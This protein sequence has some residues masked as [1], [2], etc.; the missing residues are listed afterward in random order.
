MV[1]FVTGQSSLFGILFKRLNALILTPQDAHQIPHMELFPYS[2][3]FVAKGLLAGAL[4]G[5]AG[6]VSKLAGELIYP[7]R[8]QGQQPPPAILA[9]KIAGHPLSKPSQTAATQV[10]HW[11]FSVGIGAIYGVAAEFAPVVTIGYGIV[12]GE[13]V[14]LTTH[15][16]TLPLLGLNEPPLQQPAREQKSEI[17]TH[18]M[19]GVTV[20]AVRRLLMRR[21]RQRSLQPAN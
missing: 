15:E 11:T 13:I 7:P 5:L 6:G 14:L 9:E 4:G 1:R 19:Y 20:E 17:I 16:S 2:R 8:T 21:W 10:F 18:A 3:R 12:F